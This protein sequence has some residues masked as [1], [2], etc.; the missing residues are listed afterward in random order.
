MAEGVA[1]SRVSLLLV[2]RAPAVGLPGLEGREEVLVAR[3]GASGG[4]P[5]LE[6]GLLCR[7]H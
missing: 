2:L 1:A 4:L 3:R 6:E 5:T 7:A